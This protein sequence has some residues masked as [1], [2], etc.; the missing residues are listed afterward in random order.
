M[1]DDNRYLAITLVSYVNEGSLFCGNK[2]W[3]LSLHFPQF[4]SLYHIT[5]L[6]VGDGMSNKILWFT[7][8]VRFCYTP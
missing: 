8:M 3:K 1:K 7:C 4:H 2:C 5:R 6:F